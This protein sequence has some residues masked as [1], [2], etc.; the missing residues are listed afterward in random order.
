[1]IDISLRSFGRKMP[2]AQDPGAFACAM[3][4]MEKKSPVRGDRLMVEHRKGKRR[5]ART[6]EG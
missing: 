3:A 6:K 5:K 1:M 4:C 2:V